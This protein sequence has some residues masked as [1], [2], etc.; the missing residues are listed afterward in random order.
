MAFEKW[1]TQKTQKTVEVTDGK[2]NK[3]TRPKMQCSDVLLY[4][5]SQKVVG[6]GKY[7][8]LNCSM[9]GGRKSDEYDGETGWNQGL[10]TN[11][12]CRIDKPNPE[13]PLTELEEKDYSNGWVRVYGVMSCTHYMNGQGQD[14]PALVIW[15]TRVTE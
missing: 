8:R 12:M 7:L 9:S 4:C 13:C 6:D 15:A 11:V 10:V 3:H 5:F 14:V 2:G 1:N